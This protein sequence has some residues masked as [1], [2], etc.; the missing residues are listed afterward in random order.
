MKNTL[1][2]LAASLTVFAIMA[3]P[4]MAQST[5]A[6][7]AELIT[8]LKKTYPLETCVVS[9]DKLVAGDMGPPIDFL[10]EIQGKETRLVRF[11]CKGCIKSFKKNP[12]KYLKMI[13]EAATKAKGV[14]ASVSPRSAPSS[15]AHEGH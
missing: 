13:D 7:K 14:N 15:P 10:Y 1:T 3:T 2:W 6:A 12:D 8:Q 5:E 9:G 11:C 4:L